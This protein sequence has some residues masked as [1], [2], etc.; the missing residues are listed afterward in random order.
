M[1]EEN[2]MTNQTPSTKKTTSKNSWIG[3]L[4]LLTGLV[5]SV[6]QLLCKSFFSEDSLSI[7]LSLSPLFFFLYELVVILVTEKKRKTATP[8]QLVNLYMGMKVGRMLLSLVYVLIYYLVAGVQLRRFVL[9]FVVVYLI[10]LLFDTL[11]LTKGEKKTK[12]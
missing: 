5:V 8:N 7:G 10:Y 11:Y 3:Y 1:T 4:C 12:A 6:M 9:V 2:D